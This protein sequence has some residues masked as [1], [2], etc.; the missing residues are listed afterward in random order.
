YV[1][2]DFN[3]D[4]FDHTG[5]GFFG[6]GSIIANDTGARPILNFGPLPPNTPTWGSAWK[7]AVKQYYNRSV[8]FSMQAESPAYRQNYFDLDP[9]YKDAYGLPLLRLTFNYT[10]NERKMVKWVADNVLTKIA[11]QMGGSAMAVNDKL[12]DYSI[13]PYNSTHLTG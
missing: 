5:L 3:S 10:D 7:A 2:D 8:G 12:T 4:N 6:G 9:T 1:I 11:K 13:V